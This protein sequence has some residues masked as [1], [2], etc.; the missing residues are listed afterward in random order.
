M[1]T[2]IFW[3][4]NL[5]KAFPFF[6]VDSKT[7]FNALKSPITVE[8]S[9]SGISIDVAK[10]VLEMEGIMPIVFNGAYEIFVHSFLE[11][12]IKFTDIVSNIERIL[13][14]MENRDIEN[15]DHIYEIDHQV[16]NLSYSLI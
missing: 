12:K 10:E 8:I 14:K 2:F 11:N 16:R 7:V 4:R 9:M 6:P 1:S 3:S 13:N 5:E 15:F